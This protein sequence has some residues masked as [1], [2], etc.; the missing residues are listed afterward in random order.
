MANQVFGAISKNQFRQLS[1]EQGLPGTSLRHQVQ[2]VDGIMWFA[3]EALG[4]CRYDGHTFQLYNN[5]PENLHS[6]SSNHINKLAVDSLGII[7]VATDYGLNAY[8]K[9]KNIFRKYFHDSKFDSSLSSNKCITVFV[10]SKNNTWVGTDK[11][12]NVKYAGSDTFNG[13]MHSADTTI[14]NSNLSIY[15]IAEQDNGAILMGTSEGLL[16]INI[17]TGQNH[18]WNFPENPKNNLLWKHTLDILP[19]SNNRIWLASTAGLYYFDVAT[20]LLTPFPFTPKDQQNYKNEGFNAL[21]SDDNGNIWAGALTK[22]LLVFNDNNFNYTLY[23]ENL[24]STNNY[25]TDHVRYLFKD[26]MGLV[27]IGTKFNGIIQYNTNIDVFSNW[28]SNYECLK[29]ISDQYM[30]SFWEDTDNIYWLGTKQNGLFKVDCNNNQIIQIKND[31]D[32]PGSLSSNRVNSIFRD[33][34]DNLWVG[35]D[36]GLS[37]FENKNKFVNYANVYVNTIFEDKTGVVWVGTTTGAYIVDHVNSS[38]KRFEYNGDADLFNSRQIDILSIYEDGNGT[39]WLASRNNGVYYYSYLNNSCRQL[40]ITDDSNEVI[41]T[42]MVRGF[43]EDS[44]GRFWLCTKINGICQINNEN[45]IVKSYNTNHGLSSNMILNIEE[46]INHNLWLGTHNGLIKLNP[47]DENI[48]NFNSDHGIASNIFEIGASYKLHNNNLLFG[49]NKGFNIFNP[50]SIQPTNI[51]ANLV[52]TSLKVNDVEVAN[53]ITN[54]TSIKLKHKESLLSVEFTLTDYNN[55]MRHQYEVMLKGFDN[56]WKKIGNR[57]YVSYINLKPGDYI[58]MLRGI[59]EYGNTVNSNLS[60]NITV[61]KPFYLKY[62]FIAFIV[63]LILMFIAFVYHQ[64]RKTRTTLEQLIAERTR[65]LEIAYKEL[66]IKNT[67]IREQNRQIELHHQELENKVTERTRDLEIAKRKAEESD[68]LK[69]SF[70][71]NMS[72][73]IRTPLNAISGFST[74]VSSDIYN[75]DRKQK[76]VSIIKANVSSLLKLVEDILDI[77]KIE[78][79][80]LNIEKEFFNFT[81]LFSEINAVYQQEVLQKHEKQVKLICQNPILDDTTV[82]FYSDPIRIRQ[83]LVNLLGN[84]IK[85]TPF[86]KI[87]VGY[88]LNI[89]SILFWVRDT[90]IGIK[91][92]DVDA[93]FNRFTKIEEENAIYRG[94]GLGLSISKSLVNM[95][96]G[97]IWV[98]SEH[99]IGS[100]FYFELPGEIRLQRNWQSSGSRV[101]PKSLNLI[102]ESVLI[103][104]PERSSYMLLHSFLVGTKVKI[105]WANDAKSAIEICK[106]NQFSFVLLSLDTPDADGFE[107]LKQLKEISPKL[108]IIAQ[109]AYATPQEKS[110]LSTAGF[111]SF[112]IKPFLREDLYEKIA[113]LF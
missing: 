54:D 78:A 22:G 38:L 28:P 85:F 66:L 91:I 10:D 29:S 102:N 46:D 19:V 72:H 20:E 9:K 33:S 44:K 14:I 97:R 35:T 105:T 80:Q 74:L 34:K 51:K 104:E 62:W 100:S 53:Y 107:L 108:P 69:S 82:E 45:K 59:N 26:R 110:K 17:E 8:D 57:N 11:G 63:L 96:G 18:L 55:P 31:I 73:E 30:L 40:S 93:I 90:G 86:G 60:M 16:I 68:K 50:Q 87:E 98:E 61:L 77:S 94:T 6:I 81:S 70:L 12:V 47:D 89:D 99:N 92:D 52:I 13:F 23:S 15:S 2:D 101:K 37:L 71:A 76:Y 36:L 84:A 39:I 4:L 88:K 48:T 7:W 43:F 42:D 64:I 32:K 56:N 65:K 109:V 112:L 3:V 5:D 106:N 41:N 25:K 49:G 113:L 24:N 27:W 111:S 95:M 79:G 75:A 1:Y 103:V 21:L 67:K 83:I 58:L